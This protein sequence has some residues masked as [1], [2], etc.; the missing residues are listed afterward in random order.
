MKG[1]GLVRILRSA[2]GLSLVTV[3]LGFALASFPAPSAANHIVD[4]VYKGYDSAGEK[5]TLDVFAAD[6]GPPFGLRD[7]V[8]FT[9]DYCYGG[10]F[11]S[12]MPVETDTE[13][14]LVVG[15]NV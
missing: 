4:G 6:P 12:A 1:R 11:T 3:C 7:W 15:A 14:P 9:S 10:F 13:P 5:V 8:R 2:R